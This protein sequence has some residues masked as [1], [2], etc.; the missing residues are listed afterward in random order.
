MVQCDKQPNETQATAT[1]STGAHASA[2]VDEK[3]TG[4]APL[5][6]KRPTTP[7]GF[8]EV[9]VKAVIPTTH[10][11]AV[12]LVDQQARRALLVFLGETEA[13]SI[14]LRLE[15]EQYKRPLTHDLFD[16]VLDGLSARVHSVRVDRLDGDVF[17]GVVTIE[18]D[19]T[20]RDYDSRTSDAIALALGNNAPIFVAREVLKRA[21]VELDESGMPSASASLP[22]DPGKSPISL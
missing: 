22:T 13:L 6:R 10:G 17:F 7:K 8:V 15:G 16:D 9:S 20:R 12:M 19:Q 5:P 1:S 3:P 21:S 4:A 18:K 14:H 11:N 2:S